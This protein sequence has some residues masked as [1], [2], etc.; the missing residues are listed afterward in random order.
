MLP[1]DEAI[2]EIAM[3]SIG[4]RQYLSRGPLMEFQTC[5]LSGMMLTSTNFY[6]SDITL[7]SAFE[8][9]SHKFHYTYSLDNAVSTNVVWC[10]LI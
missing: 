10:P 1:G 8:L 7:T 2:I 4:H 3:S 6:E 5:T 9:T